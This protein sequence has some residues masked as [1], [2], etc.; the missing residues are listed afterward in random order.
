MK[1]IVRQAAI[2]F[3]AGYSRSQAKAMELF[4]IPVSEKMSMSRAVTEL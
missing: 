2:Y 4:H 3:S 1:K